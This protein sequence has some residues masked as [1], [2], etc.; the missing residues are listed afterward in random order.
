MSRVRNPAYLR[1]TGALLSP[2]AILS[3]VTTLSCGGDSATNPNPEPPNPTAAR[4]LSAISGA[5]QELFAGSRSTDPFVVRVLD[6]RGQPVEEETVRF[7]VVGSAT[8]VLS[9]PEG[10]TDQDGFVETYI[11]NGTPG[12][13]EIQA[14]VGNEMVALSFEVR[15]APGTLNILPGTGEVG[16]PGQLHPDSIIEAQVLDTQGAPM[17]GVEVI[18]IAPG[19]LT[20]IRDTTDTDGIARTILRKAKLTASDQSVIGFII[21]F[22]SVF[23][24]GQRALR[25]V[26]NRAILISI[27]GLRGDAIEQFAP[28]TLSAMVAEGA[29]TSTAKTITPSLTVPAH[30]S[31]LSSVGPDGH[32]LFTDELR[33][34]EEM[35]SLDP[36]FKNARRRGRTA[37]AFMAEDGPLEN[38]RDILNCRLAF[39]LDS[40]T[41]VP[42]NAGQVVD[43]A[44]GDLQDP[45]TELIFLHI[46][47]VDIAG[48]LSGWNSQAYRDALFAADAAI[49]RVLD[50]V[51]ENTLVV[52]TSDHGGGGD[53]G[54]RLHGSSAAEDINIPLLVWGPNV[55]NVGLGSPSILDVAPT[56]LWSIGLDPPFQYEGEILLNGFG[57]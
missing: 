4:S 6:G 49:A 47:D 1:R 15:R 34:T 17:E 14:S 51:D 12:L 54:S 32:G 28:P 5:G 36:L 42:A 35:A 30:L 33:F 31:L 57:L 44:I 26:A 19:Q 53:F 55:S 22:P 9:Q 39:G 29:F 23:G 52:V 10:L 21:G 56:I 40:L 24:V 50:A 11:L 20:T 45:N 27:D 8:G 13:G 25:P 3:V 38:F 37:V 7:T 18:F 2:I 43:A 46:P 48:H 41:I 16:L